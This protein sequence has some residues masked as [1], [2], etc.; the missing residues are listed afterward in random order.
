MA[1][2]G[3]RVQPGDRTTYRKSA[4]SRDESPQT[5]PKKALS[6]FLGKPVDAGRELIRGGI[7][8]PLNIL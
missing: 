6:L 2:K 3:A 7:L 4:Q 8:P 1:G 5:L